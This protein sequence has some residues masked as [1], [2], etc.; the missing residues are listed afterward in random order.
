MTEPKTALDIFEERIGP[1]DPAREALVQ[2]FG[3]LKNLQEQG[4]PA[5]QP[6]SK[7]FKSKTGS[8]VERVLGFMTGDDDGEQDPTGAG[9]FALTFAQTEAG[10]RLAAS[11]GLGTERQAGRERLKLESTLHALAVDL[12]PP[13]DVETAMAQ[14]RSG[15]LVKSKLAFQA[16][17]ENLADEA[18]N[19]ERRA[20]LDAQEEN[21]RRVLT[22]ARSR[23]T[24]DTVGR[25]LGAAVLFALSAGNTGGG[26]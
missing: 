23:I 24:I 10:V 7:F 21:E 26:E 18:R 3:E 19:T 5:F 9:G 20:D 2:R 16:V 11:L 13:E 15:R 6:G 4:D 17:L 14:V 1:D 12:L 22:Q 8:W 25:D